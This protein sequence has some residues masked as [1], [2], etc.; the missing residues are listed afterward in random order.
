LEQALQAI[1]HAVL[2]VPVPLGWALTLGL[3][4]YILYLFSQLRADK[5][6][7][8]IREFYEWLCS[9]GSGKAVFGLISF[10][11]LFILIY[12]VAKTEIPFLGIAAISWGPWS[13]LSALLR[14]KNGKK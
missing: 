3:F 14:I 10:S 9:R 7:I 6:N 8:D 4:L 12:F 5:V 13:A 1:I 11:I 2:Q